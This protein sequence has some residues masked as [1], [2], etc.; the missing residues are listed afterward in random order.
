MALKSLM[1]VTGVILVLFLLAHMYGNL[2]VFGGQQAFDEYSHH[3]RELGEPMLPHSGALWIIRVVL[4]ASV[5]GHAYSAVALWSRA[6][7]ARGH[8][9]AVTKSA[10]G[11]SARYATQTM[12]WGGVVIVL[13]VVFHILHLTT[14]DIAPGGASTSPYERLVNGFQ[15]EFWYVTLFYVL[16]VLAVGLHLRHG[17]WSALATLGANKAKRERPLHAASTLIAVVLTVGFLL[18]PLSVT[19]GLVE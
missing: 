7:K 4:L 14:N 13:F 12:R 2:M 5:L 6:K 8:R 3:L 11:A 16:S 10:Q 1:A 17:I 9:Y 15:P 18:G 19:F